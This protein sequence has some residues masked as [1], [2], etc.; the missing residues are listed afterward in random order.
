MFVA[1][2]PVKIID[3]HLV[4]SFFDNYKRGYLHT[5]IELENKSAWIAECSLN[6]QVTTEV[7]DSIFLVEH[8]Q[9]HHVSV[10]AKSQLQYTFPPVSIIP[11]L[12]LQQNVGLL[13]AWSIFLGTLINKLGILK[14]DFQFITLLSI[15]IVLAFYCLFVFHVYIWLRVVSFVERYNL[16]SL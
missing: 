10:P 16:M 14:I 8:L 7:E 13:S 6:I 9:T 12:L 5:T 2:Q 11:V 1:L 4:S 15:C 3:P